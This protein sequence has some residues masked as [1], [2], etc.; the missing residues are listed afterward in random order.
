MFIAFVVHFFYFR[1]FISTAT[2]HEK[3]V[4]YPRTIKTRFAAAAEWLFIVLKG[5][6]LVK[7]TRVVLL[8]INNK[9]NAE[10][11]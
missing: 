6:R 1:E 8:R 11:E 2:I 9:K 5:I 7:T 3:L 4:Q 10:R